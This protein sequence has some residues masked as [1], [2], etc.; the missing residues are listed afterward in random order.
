MFDFVQISDFNFMK[1]K[2]KLSKSEKIRY[3]SDN[4]KSTKRQIRFR[5]CQEWKYL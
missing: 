3:I 1:K 5:K 4:I 2:Q